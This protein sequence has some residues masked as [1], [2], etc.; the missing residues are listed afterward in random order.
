[1]PTRGAQIDIS[2]TSLFLQDRVT[3]G[4]HWAFDLG[5]RYEHVGS[6][7][8]VVSGGVSANTVVPRLGASFDPRGNGRTVLRTT[9]AHYAGK[10]HDVQFGRNTNVGNADSYTTTYTGPAGQGLDFAPGFDTANYSRLVGGTFPRDNVRFADDLSAPLTKEVTIGIDQQLTSR[11][12]A[13]VAYVRRRVG[14]FVEDFITLDGGTTTIARN[15]LTFGTFDNVVWKNTDLPQR[16]YQ[17]IDVQGSFRAAPA[18]RVSA[19]WTVQIENNGN[20]EGE[21]PNNPAI[22]TAL[23]DYPEMLVAGRNYP[24]G[25]LDDFQRHRLRLWGIYSLGMGRAGTIDVAP[26][27]RVNSGRTYSLV[28]N[29]VALTPVQLANNPGYVGAPTQSVFFDERGSESFKGVGLVDLAVTYGVPVWRTASPW[30]KFELLNVMNNQKQLSWD[31][32]V[33]PDSAGPKDANGLPLTSVTGARFGQA[34][35][36]GDFPRPRLGMDG[37]RTFL[38]S[39]GARF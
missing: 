5:M 8:T 6:R 1:M 21:S 18:L 20:F 9:Y 19:D 16:H 32:T 14:N 34:V 37:G 27:W 15:G 12:Q 22:G 28:A 7:A 3:A 33:A 17:A 25:R 13:H 38:M 39:M 10:Y 4:A 36:T 35:R 26:L 31:A 29:G 11:A 2:T 24:T 30:V 23:G